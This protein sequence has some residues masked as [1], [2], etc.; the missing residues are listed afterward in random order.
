MHR[1]L[2]LALPL[3]ATASLCLA[4]APQDPV[5]RNE[6]LALTLGQKEKGSVLSLVD[7]ATGS[8]FIA[9]EGATRL[10]SLAF[11]KKAGNGG[12]RFYLS[13]GNAQQFTVH[14]EGDGLRLEYQD[15]GGRPVRVTCTVRAPQNDP[16]IR[17]R[18]AVTVPE[19]LVLEQV[20]YPILSLR[21]PLGAKAEDDAAVFGHTK[22]GVVRRPV[23]MKP[24]SRISG[25]FPGSLAAQFACCYDDAAG[26]YLAAY[27]GRGWPK[28]FEMHRTPAGLDFEWSLPCFASGCFAPDFDF[29]TTTFRAQQALSATSWRDAADLY[30]AWALTQPWCATLFAQRADVPAWMKSGPAMV[31]FSREWLSQPALIRRWLDEYWKKEFAGVPLIV[32]F[33]GWEKAGSW[34]TPDYFPVYP[35]DEQFAGLVRHLRTLGGHAFP[36]PSGYHWTLTFR[37]KEDGSFEWDD[38]ARFDS[39]GRPHAVHNRDGQ[40]Y[41]RDPSWLS[42]GQ[43]ACLCPGD[44][45]TL[46]WWNQ[47]IT[48]PLNRRG[49]ELVQVDQ[50]VG[51]RFPPCYDTRHP[52]PPGPGPWMTEVFTRQL[53]SMFDTSR[54]IE[55]EAV[56][57]YEEP[58][59]MFNHLAAIQD[60]RDC[61]TSHEFASVF[62]YLY[63]EF[64]PTFQSN[65]RAGD[66]VRA[67]HCAASGQMP[68][69]VPSRIFGDS[70]ALENGGFEEPGGK[71]DQP[72]GWDAVKEYNGQQ[73]KG[74]GRGDTSVKRSG[75]ASLRLE[76]AAE[77][78]IVQISQ[79]VRLLG[80]GLT[81]GKRCR[82]SAWLKSET[83]AR[84]N[85]I[86]FGLFAPELKHL[87]GG[88]LPFPPA[89][90]DWTPV[91][92]EFTVPP[93]AEMLRI[94]IHLSGPAKTWVDDLSLEEL[95]ENGAAQ[96]V[97][98]SRDG[99]EE[100]FLKRWVDLYHGEGRPWLQFGRTLHPPAL[101]CAQ[102][103][104]QNKPLPAVLHNAY[105]AADG[106]EAV[107]LANATRDPQP[108]KLAWQGKEVALN[109][110]P[111]ELKLLR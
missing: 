35:S 45:W 48:A 66:L 50:V 6:R 32:A 63:H 62:N 41:L 88:R 51:G 49:C 25:Q 59:E 22:G 40:L 106:S 94:M 76:N 77:G 60:Y 33:W 97:L 21:A 39:A 2:S 83:L 110:A 99:V 58:N 79:N 74:Q 27:D 56:V 19:D 93:G 92:A 7:L 9:R 3:A 75:A 65:P 69:L 64:L 80:A 5:L 43:T 18:I 37:K 28:N 61:E 13:S 38:R 47:D 4:T 67:A 101:S 91:Q 70:P 52:H 20:H 82:L 78:D 44:P 86:N 72:Q 34:V 14:P 53:R 15:L 104:Y 16:Q 57:C 98:R 36:W 100:G 10:F 54:A 24:G 90:A 26:L 71:P 12:E 95:G 73:W 68:H 107:I 55:P 109:L 23:W 108:V 1:V 42:G 30:K 17:W 46:N 105:R 89:G 31:R 11:T 29:V 87:A 85:A 8:E 96:V 102:I 103:T 84:P 81:P 111:G